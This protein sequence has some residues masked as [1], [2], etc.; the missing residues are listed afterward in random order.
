VSANQLFEMVFSVGN[1]LPN[2]AALL[3]LFFNAIPR[4]LEADQIM[5]ITPAPQDV[6]TK[7]P[8]ILKIA[9]SDDRTTAEIKG[10]MEA[11]YIAWKLDVRLILDV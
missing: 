6:E 5:N 4:D 7:H 10:L 1:I 2:H 3:L 8:F 11:L 9:N